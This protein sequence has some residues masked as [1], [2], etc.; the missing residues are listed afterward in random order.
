V[1][2][3]P[4]TYQIGPSTV[5]VSLHCLRR[6]GVEQHL[7]HKAFQT[8][9][10]LIEHRDRVVP[11]EELFARVWKDAAVTD[12]T[13]VQ[14]ISEIRK[15]LGDDPQNPRYIKTVLRRGYR[16]VGPVDAAP[17]T[18]AVAPVGA[19]P[20][21]ATVQPTARSR[22]WVG[23]VVV[24]LALGLFGVAIFAFR[25]RLFT[26]SDR[27]PPVRT[28]AF[29]PFTNQSGDA[30]LDWLREGLPDMLI[31][32][33]ARAPELNVISRAQVQRFSDRVQRPA[34]SIDL[35]TALEIGRASRSDVVVLGGI[36]KLGEA[37]RIDVHLHAT[38][39]GE[40]LSAQSLTVDTAERLLTDVDLLSMR[41]A[42]AL[43]AAG[44]RPAVSEVMTNSLEAYR[45]Y[46]LALEEAHAYN[47][48]EALRLLEHATTL[49]PRFAMAYARI[50]YIY[51]IVR[52]NEGDRAR[53][54][55]EKAFKLADRLSDKDRLYIDAWYSLSLN[56]EERGIQTLRRIVAAYPTETEAYWR[57][58]SRLEYQNRL[59]EAIASYE[60]GLAI[61]PGAK[62]IW[63]TLGFHYSAVGR[64]DRAIEAHERYV[65]LDPQEANAHDSLGM[66]YTQ[67]GRMGQALAALERALTLKPDFHFPILHKG[68]VFFLLGRHRD[69]LSHYRRYIEIAPSDWDRAVGYNH[70][71]LL[72]LSHGD[73]AKAASAARQERILKNDFG[74]A[75]RV[76]LVSGNL[77]EARQL[78]Q[79]YP[80]TGAWFTKRDREYVFGLF[81]L[82]EGR[83]DDAIARFQAVLKIPAMAWGINSLEDALASAY[84]ELGRVDEAIEESRRV[85]RL[86]EQDPL[87]HYGLAR[88]LD[89]RG[90]VAQARASYE[91]FLQIWKDAD[92]DIPQVRTA[93]ARLASAPARPSR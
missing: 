57:L 12:D 47:T 19:L 25:D 40:L 31:A 5:D 64:Y 73:I 28:V 60:R 27:T 37:I 70:V 50:G 17:E 4:S 24:C 7:R 46:S 87:T 85:L 48:N 29:T 23:A 52:V 15:A 58:G 30:T 44:D 55:L 18:E 69:A 81:A 88:A 9:L 20:P 74:T 77:T 62:E 65:A 45:A 49:D 89:A 66:T 22:P 91:R 10:Y 11:K 39:S 56:D 8:L 33:L 83:A 72:H 80:A 43:G 67:A 1:S 6:D 53:P 34:G 93:R 38:G 92:P 79:L 84:M 63:N 35:N 76:A 32:G 21:E 13:L 90:E 36:A 42:R 2:T 75:L 78:K 86:N 59:D 3:G 54:Y 82:K 16:F 68:D 51:A 14:C 41:V 26:E 61:D 71:A